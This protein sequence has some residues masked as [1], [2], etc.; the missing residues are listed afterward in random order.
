MRR[1]HKSLLAFAATTALVALLLR[2]Q[3]REESVQGVAIA[4]MTPAQ[5]PEPPQSARRPAP[6]GAPAAALAV[7]PPVFD[8][9]RLEKDEVCEGEENLATVNA[10]TTDGNDS[11][12][13]YTVDGEAGSQVPVRAYV[14]RDAS[15]PPQNAVTMSKDNVATR[16]ELPRYRVK[17]CRPARILVVTMRMLPNSVSE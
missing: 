12:L 7:A 1:K 6:P 9:V 15:G 10:H 13:H 2:S 8:L 16:I 4:A 17:S 5:P 14:G 3:R 11:F